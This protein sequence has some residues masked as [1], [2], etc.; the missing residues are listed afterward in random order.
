MRNR[1]CLK[2]TRSTQPFVRIYENSETSN[3]CTPSLVD[4]RCLCYSY[5]LSLVGASLAG[6]AHSR[7]FRV[8]VTWRCLWSATHCWLMTCSSRAG[9]PTTVTSSPT[10]CFSPPWRAL[11]HAPEVHARLFSQFSLACLALAWT[12]LKSSLKCQTF[13]T[14]FI[15]DFGVWKFGDVFTVVLC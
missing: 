1:T 4:C 6:L 10:D 11:S 15:N 14:F 7:A 2:Y 13:A 5:L 9:R 12:V 8:H 3:T